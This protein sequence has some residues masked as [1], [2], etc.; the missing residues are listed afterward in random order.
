[1]GGWSQLARR[2]FSVLREPQ[3][4]RARRLGLA[5]AGPSHGLARGVCVTPEGDGAARVHQGCSFLSL[6]GTE[7]DAQSELPRTTVARC[8][9]KCV[10]P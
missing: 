1:M 8:G 9:R 2:G 6:V 3:V 7:G 5:A 4:G 10:E